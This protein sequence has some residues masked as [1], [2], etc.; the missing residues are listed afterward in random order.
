VSSTYQRVASSASCALRPGAASLAH[1]GILFLDEAPEFDRGVLD[2]LREPVETGEIVLSRAA[3]STRFPARF[4][5]VLAANPCPCAKPGTACTCSGGVRSRYLSKLSGPLLDRI[6]LTIE[7]FP[8]S[9][10][11]L[12]AD[13]AYAESSRAVAERVASA[14][15]RA[16]RRLAGTP[17]HTNADVPGAELRKRFPIASAALSVLGQ[18]LERGRVTARGLDRL[19]RLSWTLADL[20]ERDAPSAEDTGLA[21]ALSAGTGR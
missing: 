17:W 2:A 20:A 7:L 1:H 12:L 18:A 5:L 10:A 8:V 9:R 4:M 19:L 11:E 16:A 3:L 14:R 21:L 13:R 6:D 15:D